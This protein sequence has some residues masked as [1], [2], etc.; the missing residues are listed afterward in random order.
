MK[1]IKNIIFDLGGVVI[2][3]DRDRA[4]TAL[5]SLGIKNA[6]N[7]LGLYEQAGPFLDL[8]KGNITPAALYDELL[9]LCKP[10]TK[11]TDID[12]A[13]EEFLLDLPVERLEAARDLRKK[14]YRLFVLSNTNPI[15]FND[16]IE[17]AFRA[18]GLSINDYFDGVVTS[19]QEHRCK[20]DPELFL[21]VARR[22][23]LKP[24]ETLM[25][26]DSAANCAAAESV[27]FK[28]IR[29][30]NKS[31]DSLVNVCGRISSDTHE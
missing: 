1:G 21:T 20:P 4:A 24:E 5:E 2:D 27:G 12:R 16:W 8:E 23:G 19:F 25:L 29:I 13:F 15:M 3:L 31:D 30:D 17:K 28:A 10:G 22:Y 7:L 9:P 6:P 18:E 14:G 11:P 26:D